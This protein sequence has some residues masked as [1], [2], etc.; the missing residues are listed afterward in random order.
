MLRYNN[1]SHLHMYYNSLILLKSVSLLAIIKELEEF[2][3]GKNV[4]LAIIDGARLHSIASLNRST[5][6]KVFKQCL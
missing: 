1:V 5:I 2:L 4:K 6:Y 3:L